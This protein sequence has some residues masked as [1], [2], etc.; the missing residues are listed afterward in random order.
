MQRSR[1]EI[2]V[3][4]K[5]R[6]GTTALDELYQSG[7]GKVKLARPEPGRLKEAVIINTTG[8]LTDGDE[9][10]S[11]VHWREDTSAIVTTQAAER[12]Y[13]SRSGNAEIHSNLTID[14]GACG[15]W[16]PQETILFDGGRLKRSNSIEVSGNGQL[17]A[18][19]SCVFGRTAMGE[20][21]N[22]G[23]F[24][25]GWQVKLDGKLVLADR[26]ELA[27]NIQQKLDRPA[28]ANGA[29]ALAT[30]VHVAANAVEAC[31][32]IR[33]TIADENAI[34]GCSSLGPLTITRLFGKNAYELRQTTIR[35]LDLLMARAVPD[36]TGSLLPRVWR[37]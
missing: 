37:L 15:L 29:T 9:F 24:S 31:E 23:F 16:L 20:I 3:S 11:D 30:I 13:L 32:N 8:G 25:D 4:F 17:I 28:I 14:D 6:D 5:N 2:R 36:I 12:I 21:V 19:E 1:G 10:V 26:F 7:S 35:V 18:V 34:G 27:G 22:D 33:N